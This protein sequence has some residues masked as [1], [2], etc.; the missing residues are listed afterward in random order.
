MHQLVKVALVESVEI[1][2]SKVNSVSSTIDTLYM[3]PQQER[4]VRA[5]G[6]SVEL[7]HLPETGVE[8][9]RVHDRAPD[10]VQVTH[11]KEMCLQVKKIDH[12]VSNQSP[13]I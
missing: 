2:Q 1:G 13:H 12:L 6:R 9:V 4:N 8:Q 5:T 3:I 10:H 11:R 7:N